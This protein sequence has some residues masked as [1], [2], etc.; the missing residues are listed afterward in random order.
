MGADASY[1][2][3][4]K[5]G[6][7]WYSM[8]EVDASRDYPLFGLLA[9]IRRRCE[10]GP[11]YP[12]RGEPEDFDPTRHFSDCYTVSVGWLTLDELEAVFAEREK[13]TTP[14]WGEPAERGAILA[15]MRSLAES[16][17]GVR[18]VFGFDQG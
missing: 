2:I 8:F 14:G 9:G 12:V 15:V 13:D 6:G 16:T 4:Y 18:F 1:L 10:E 3:E 5:R 11:L 7:N 17:D